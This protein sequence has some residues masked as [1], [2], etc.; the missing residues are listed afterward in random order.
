MRRELFHI[1]GPFSIQSY[2]LAIVIGILV[3]SWLLLEH[4]KRKSL[5]SADQLINI[6]MYGIIF[7]LLGGRLLALF[8]NWH[9]TPL[10]MSFIFEGGF[11]VLGS[12][13]SVIF[14]VCI[15][16]RKIHVS[17]LPFLDLLAIHAPLLQSIG[18]VGCFAAGCCFGKITSAPWSVCYTDVNSY[19]PLYNNIHP[20][21]LYSAFLL[22]FLFILLYGGLQYIIK[23]N[24]QLFMIYLMGISLERFIV[25]FYRADQE[26][27]SG[28][29]LWSLHQLIAILIFTTAVFGF[30]VLMKHDVK[31]SKA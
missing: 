29:T 15:Y 25:D 22:L 5:V 1:F 7:G 11:S 20:T 12:I 2:G 19:A 16:L 27:I 8:Y 14:F 23:K 3:F 4:P 21:Q 24:G 28:I 18:R 30:I 17:V 9:Q 31:Y 13:I 26:W 6:V 10:D